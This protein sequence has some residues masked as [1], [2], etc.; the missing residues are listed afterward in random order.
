[1]RIFN[2]IR[3]LKKDEKIPYQL[4]LL[5]D[6]SKQLID[7]YLAVSTL[8]I[9]EEAS[10]IY[11]V[12]VLTPVD[13]NIAE[14]KNIAVGESHQGK[15]IGSLLLRHAEDMAR[16]KGYK[17]LIIGTGNS[18]IG[19]LYLYQKMGFEICG[20]KKDFFVTNYKEALWEN[21]IQCKHMILLS[22]TL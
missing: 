14:I 7:Q 17:T 11:G 12:Y 16:E 6:P 15:G 22:K 5:A 9:A 21:H 8:Y 19:Q 10:V 13:S 2:A 18:S 4:L 3:P 20:I 1:M